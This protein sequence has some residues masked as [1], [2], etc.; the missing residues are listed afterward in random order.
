MML[1]NFGRWATDRMCY[2]FFFKMTHS[3][4]WTSSQLNLTAINF[5][6]YLLINKWKTLFYLKMFEIF[7]SLH[8]VSNPALLLYQ[9][10]SWIKKFFSKFFKMITFFWMNHQRC[11]LKSGIIWLFPFEYFIDIISGRAKHGQI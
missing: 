10:P 2:W 7:E 4:S 1:H 3:L 8:H 5:N 6:H 9:S 11:T